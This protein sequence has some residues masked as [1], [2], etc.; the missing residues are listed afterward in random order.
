MEQQTQPHYNARQRES[1][2]IWGERPEG[3][4]V[5]EGPKKDL[6]PRAAEARKEKIFQIK[7]L[8]V[9]KRVEKR[10]QDKNSAKCV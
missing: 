1:T 4:A 6:G 3:Q 5:W 8:R 2:G 7:R 9:G 10:K